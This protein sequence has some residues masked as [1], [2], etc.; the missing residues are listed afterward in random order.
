MTTMMPTGAE[1]RPETGDWASVVAALGALRQEVA[2]LGER[3][4]ALEAGAGKVPAPVAA[5]EAAAETATVTAATPA[6][7][8]G[9][10]E[11]LV[12]VIG[13]AIAAFLGKKPHIRQI[14]LLGSAAWAQQ[15]RVTIQASHALSVPHR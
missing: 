2:R 11:E 9:L 12:L 10:S 14:R 13:A 4:A 5:P 7:A 15:G 8:E 3:V 6:P 1:H